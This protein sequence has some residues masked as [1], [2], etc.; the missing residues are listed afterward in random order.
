MVLREAAGRLL[1]G[2]GTFVCKIDVVITALYD[3]LK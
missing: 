1:V 3:L 2:M